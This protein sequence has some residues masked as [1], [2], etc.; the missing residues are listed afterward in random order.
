MIRTYHKN[1]HIKDFNQLKGLIIID[2]KIIIFKNFDRCRKINTKILIPDILE[3]I[4]KSPK[5]LHETEIMDAH[6]KG[7]S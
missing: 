1:E 6:K 2:L 3:P 7:K 4:T 5:H